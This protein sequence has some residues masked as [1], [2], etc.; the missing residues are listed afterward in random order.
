MNIA[1]PKISGTDELKK[2]SETKLN[3]VSLPRVETENVPTAAINTPVQLSPT[4][5]PDANKV[6]RCLLSSTSA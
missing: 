6:P 3:G 4:I 2:L 1:R 5:K